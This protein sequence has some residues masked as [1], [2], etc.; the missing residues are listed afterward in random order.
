MRAAFSECQGPSDTQEHRGR[1]QASRQFAGGGGGI[2]EESI[3]VWYAH[4]KAR[5]TL[6]KARSGLNST[7]ACV[8]GATPAPAGG[9]GGGPAG[10]PRLTCKQGEQE[11]KGMTAHQ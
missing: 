7:M 5:A 1:G 11:H 10:S 6:L 4:A 9:E 2:I 3:R 8:A